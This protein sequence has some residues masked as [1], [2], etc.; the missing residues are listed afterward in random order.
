MKM[1]TN[2]T[3]HVTITPKVLSQNISVSAVARWWI[4]SVEVPGI[5]KNGCEIEG[6]YCPWPADKKID[7]YFVLTI[8]YSIFQVEG[9]VNIVLTNEESIII[10][11]F[12]V[13]AQLVR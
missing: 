12:Q 9:T 1:G 2:V 4:F 6:V 5:P 8:P 10:G 13:I 3:A 11:C 7:L